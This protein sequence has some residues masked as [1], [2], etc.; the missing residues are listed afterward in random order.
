MSENTSPANES[1]SATQPAATNQDNASV[2]TS[3]PEA[4]STESKTE[5][6]QPAKKEPKQGVRDTRSNPT[7]ENTADQPQEESKPSPN[8]KGEKS[9]ND[10]GQ[11]Q[12]H[13]NNANNNNRTRGRRGRK[14]NDQTQ[15]QNQTNQKQIKLNAKSVSKKAWKIFLAEVGEEGLALIG[16]K[17]G[18]DLTKRS[19][20]LAE[21]FQ[22]EE[23][24]RVDQCKD[25]KRKKSGECDS[26]SIPVK[27]KQPRAKKAAKKVQRSE[28]AKQSDSSE[29]AEVKSDQNEVAPKVDAPKQ[30]EV[31][32]PVEAPTS[33][34]VVAEK[35]E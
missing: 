21:I 34:E 12:N 6:S 14:T 33:T 13:P 7:P 15:N 17:E 4:T 29:T 22:E 18:K 3:A 23:Q 32:A 20:R 5:K 9:K 8:I 35:P 11:Q 25:K 2:N 16:D 28:D 30:E 1:A 24:R 19:F 31:N 27:K 26:D 10:G